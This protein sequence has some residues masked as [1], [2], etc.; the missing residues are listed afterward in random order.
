MSTPSQSRPLPTTENDNLS[1]LEVQEIRSDIANLTAMVTAL[2]SSQNANG[3]LSVPS[4]TGDFPARIVEST[5]R[6]DVQGLNDSSILTGYG[7]TSTHSLKLELPKVNKF[8]GTHWDAWKA[9]II[10]LLKQA[11][12]SDHIRPDFVPP[13]VHNPMYSRWELRDSAAFG[14]IYN[15]MHEDRQAEYFVV[16]L[17]ARDFWDRLLK[18][19]ENRSDISQVLLH[20]EFNS[21]RQGPNQRLVD[22]VHAS[23]RLVARMRA[24][25]VVTDE[26]TL[27]HNLL[28]THMLSSTQESPLLYHQAVDAL[29]IHAAQRGES[30]EKHYAHSSSGDKFSAH[31]SGRSGAG[32]HNFYTKQSPGVQG[33]GT[34]EHCDNCG[35]RGHTASICR[36]K[37]HFDSNG[38]RIRNC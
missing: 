37:V 10:N 33:R 11:G 7:P 3:R 26:K 2:I 25:G 23:E 8:K 5:D 30:L 12:L 22:Y 35:R 6:G 34:H 1:V 24:L 13:S 28:I 29:L 17:S 31:Q 38:N 32:G 15:N 19:Y 14:H 36:L 21:H 20:K 16:G 18:R 27:V 9:A 4:L